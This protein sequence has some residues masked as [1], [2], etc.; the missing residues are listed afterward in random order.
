MSAL[1]PLQPTDIV[2]EHDRKKFALIAGNVYEVSRNKDG[3]FR[4]SVATD[5]VPQRAINTA[6]HQDECFLARYLEGFMH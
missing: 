6:S 3:Y 1:V 4:S 2:M 5:E